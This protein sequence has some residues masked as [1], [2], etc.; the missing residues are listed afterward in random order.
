MH[1]EVPTK[2]KQ[3]L[4][5]MWVSVDEPSEKIIFTEHYQYRF[6][7]NKKTDSSEY[8]IS[9]ESCEGDSQDTSDDSEYLS[10]LGDNGNVEFCYGISALDD[11]NLSLIYLNG[12]G[13]ISSYKKFR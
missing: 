10:L 5:G 8:L 2:E 13:A 3:L 9:M 6:E 11:S 12:N 1:K 4:Y 7:D